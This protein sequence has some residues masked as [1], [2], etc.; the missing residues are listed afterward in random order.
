MSKDLTQNRPAP[1]IEF[2]HQL[3]SIHKA[4]E[5][6]LPDTVPFKNFKNAAVVALTDNPELLR[7]DRGSL[8]KSLRTLAAIGLVPDGR[9]AAIVA[10]GGKAQALPMVWG[11]VKIARNSGKISTFWADVVYEGETLEVWV[12]DGERKWNHVKDDGTKIDAMSRGGEIRGAY[13][14]AKL[15]DGTVEFQPMSKQEVEKRRKVSASQRGANPTGVWLNWYDEQAKKTVIRNLAKRLPMSADDIERI[16]SEDD[17]NEVQL[18]DVTPEPEAPRMNAAQQIAAQQEAAQ[19][20]DGEVLPPEEEP[21]A[22]PLDFE[23]LDLKDAFPGSPYWEDGAQAAE[24]GKKITD[25]PH[26][27]I[28]KAIDWCSGWRDAMSKGGDE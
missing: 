19:Q 16:M 1:I 11:L 12:E 24:D 2:K 20:A 6:A 28:E 5:L 27:D 3:D 17:A 25:C 10:Y 26:T 18:R 7:C 21:A 22:E 4:G 13:A 23:N 15:I 8:F 9:E 14:V